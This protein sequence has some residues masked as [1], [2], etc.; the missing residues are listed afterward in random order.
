M[1]S[2]FHESLSS[3]AAFAHSYRRTVASIAA[4]AGLGIVVALI[5]SQSGTGG[6]S[7]NDPWALPAKHSVTLASPIETILAEP[8]FGGEPVLPTPDLEEI[9]IEEGSS[10]DPWQLRGI[11][12]EGEDRSVI[13]YNETL[14]KLQH[15]QLGEDLPGGE[16]LIEVRENTI[17]YEAQSERNELSLFRDLS[18]TED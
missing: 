12:I 8:L 9:V 5:A 11:V 2:V 17:A 13:V 6:L 3:I 7:Q 10:G 15:I 16:R 4:A 18:R 14:E 1:T